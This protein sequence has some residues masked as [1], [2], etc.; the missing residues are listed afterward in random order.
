MKK[1]LSFF[2]F[3]FLTLVLNA[4]TNYE[5]VYNNGS[6]FLIVG[7]YS[8]LNESLVT[9]SKGEDYLYDNLVFKVD[10]YV[11]EKF[12]E[13]ISSNQIIESRS[14]L[15][16]IRNTLSHFEIFRYDVLEARLLFAENNFYDS[17]RLLETVEVA[18]EDIENYLDLQR[19]V[20]TFLTAEIFQYYWDARTISDYIF[21]EE[22]LKYV[23]SFLSDREKYLL[24]YSLMDLQWHH[25]NFGLNDIFLERFVKSE[26]PSKYQEF[27]DRN[28]KIGSLTRAPSAIELASYL[29]SKAVIVNVFNASGRKTGN[30]SGFFINDNGLIITNE[31]V[32]RDA[33]RVS[34]QMN[35]GT[36]YDV[37]VLLTDERRDFALLKAPIE[38]NDYVT[39]G[40]SYYVRT[41]ETIYTYG[42]PLGISNTM[43]TGLVS[44]NL[45]IVNRKE[46]IQVSAPISP[47]SS[48]GMLVNEFGQVIGI[49][50]SILINGQNMNLSIPINRVINSINEI[51]PIIQLNPK[52][53][54]HFQTM[55]TQTIRQI[56]QLS[57]EEPDD[58]EKKEIF[59]FLN[60]EGEYVYASIEY[61]NGDHFQGELRN[62][63]FFGKATVITNEYRFHGQFINGAINGFG[64]TDY[65]DGSF[66]V[67]HYLEDEFHGQG[68]FY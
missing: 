22:Q 40:N 62:G 64:I 39:L 47:G 20:V 60:F 4:C 16:N 17:L 3:V 24:T 34:I 5:E 46:Y 9:L 65:F 50:T 57:F 10:E 41:G 33:S 13:L 23:F 68:S 44:K 63:E 25:L 2:L 42:S 36:L 14:F 54:G 21:I 19:E 28:A 38:N 48:G 11:I 15:N 27:F 51:D 49:T 32:I 55:T 31:H 35:N 6:E 1:H 29:E 67:G 30:G 45:S 12:N 37:T 43:T 26:M 53:N 58:S 56:H 18:S 52:D 59:G 8:E 66:Y 7:N 61:E